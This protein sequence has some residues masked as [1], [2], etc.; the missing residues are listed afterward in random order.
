MTRVEVRWDRITS[1][2]IFLQHDDSVGLYANI[3]YKF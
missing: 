2:R 1:A 3:I